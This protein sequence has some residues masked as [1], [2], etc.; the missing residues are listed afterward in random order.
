MDDGPRVPAFHDFFDREI[1]RLESVTDTSPPRPE[2]EYRPTGPLLP[3]VHGQVLIL[4]LLSPGVE[5]RSWQAQS[6][7]GSLCQCSYLIL[8]G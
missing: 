6:P 4:F 2:V 8:R 5:K 1:T 3:P 7:C